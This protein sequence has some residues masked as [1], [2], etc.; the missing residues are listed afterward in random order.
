MKRQL[1]LAGFLCLW[2]SLFVFAMQR[3]PFS[4]LAFTVE[5]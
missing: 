1:P 2:L 3:E 5:S 4:I